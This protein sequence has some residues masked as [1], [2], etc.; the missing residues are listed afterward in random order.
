LSPLRDTLLALLRA[1]RRW[2]SPL[3]GARCRFHPTCSQYASQ[4]L[5]RHGSVRG[6][7]LASTRLARCHPFSAGGP[8]PVPERFTFAPWRAHATVPETDR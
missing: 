2:L 4:A 3:L 5:E 6:L 7:Y 1:Y 8:D